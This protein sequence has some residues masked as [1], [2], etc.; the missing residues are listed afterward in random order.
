[1]YTYRIVIDGYNAMPMGA[2][3]ARVVTYAQGYDRTDALRRIRS[4]C[5][6]QDET[7]SDGIR[8]WPGT[9]NLPAGNVVA[10]TFREWSVVSMRSVRAVGR[11]HILA[12]G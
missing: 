12:E 6:A 8:P 4:L 9:R 2:R 3:P 11:P 7:V 10:R 5:V 1:M